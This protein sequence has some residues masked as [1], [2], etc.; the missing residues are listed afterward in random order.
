MNPLNS[1]ETTN[2]HTKAVHVQTETAE[3][4]VHASTVHEGTAVMVARHATKSDLPPRRAR[5]LYWISILGVIGIA[6]GAGYYFGSERLLKFFKKSD[7][8]PGHVEPNRSATISVNTVRPMRKTL[9]RQVEQAGS[10]LP[11]AQAELY[12]KVPG[13]LKHIQREFS[14]AVVGQLFLSR[15]T[16][17]AAGGYLSPASLVSG[18]LG[19]LRRVGHDAPQIDIGSVVREGE[20]LMVLDVPELNSDEAQKQAVLRQRQAELLQARALLATFEAGLEASKAKQQSAAADLHRTEA[21][22]EYREGELRRMQSLVKD[23]TVTEDLVAEKTNQRNAARAAC[24]AAQAKVDAEKAEYSVASSKFAA[25]RADVTVKEALVDVARQDLERARVLAEYT[26]IRA[27]FDGV[28][29]ERTVDEGDFV[30]NASSGQSRSLMTVT[31]VDHVKVALQIPEKEAAWTSVGAEA[32]VRLD[33]REHWQAVGRISRVSHALDQ[34]ARTMRIELDLDNTEHKLMPGMYGRVTLV[35]QRIENALA[36]PAT[37]VF[38]RRGENYIV[39]A[40]GGVARRV[41]VH[42]RFD[43]GEELDVYKMIDGKEVPLDGREELIVSNKGEIGDGQLIKAKSL[44]R[45]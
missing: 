15:A 42:I 24:E 7:A 23:R 1:S 28:V 25:A 40:E 30:Q 33:A 31:A 8:T 16:G 21:E 12:A 11:R 6:A 32:V 10:I 18:G 45:K 29:T 13:Y 34:Q 14:P 44:A 17:A 41:P 39:L 38:S 43:N 19:F 22:C 9:L 36:I 2:L 4:S 37:A 27:P 5:G 26:L 3:S 35:L 20:V